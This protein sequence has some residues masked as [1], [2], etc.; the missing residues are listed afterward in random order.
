MSIHKVSEIII[1]KRQNLTHIW[2]GNC[3][4]KGEVE[5]GQSVMFNKLHD[6]GGCNFSRSLE[7]ASENAAGVRNDVECDISR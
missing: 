7:W 2:L 5:V 1:F 6:M 4:G 3:H